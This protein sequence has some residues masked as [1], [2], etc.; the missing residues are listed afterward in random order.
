MDIAIKAAEK[1]F[2]TRW[3]RNLNLNL[4][5]RLAELTERDIDKLVT[6]EGVL[7]LGH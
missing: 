6:F 5:W 7:G 3:I 4:L 2:E 1:A